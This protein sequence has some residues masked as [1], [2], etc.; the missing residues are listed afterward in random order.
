MLDSGTKIEIKELK[1]PVTTI[2]EIKLDH[3]YIPPDTEHINRNIITKYIMA[4][5]IITTIKSDNVF[6]TELSNPLV[7]PSEI[8]STKPDINLSANCITAIKRIG[9]KIVIIIKTMPL[10]P[11]AFLIMW[12]PT[13][14]TSKPSLM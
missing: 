5:P 8:G 9:D 14:A 12:A 4:T 11:I 13:L 3:I 7:W 6:A 10:N 2:V 1:I